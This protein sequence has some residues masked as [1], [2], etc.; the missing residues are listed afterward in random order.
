[1]PGIFQFFTFEFIDIEYPELAIFAG[2]IAGVGII[3]TREGGFGFGDRV[4]QIS[5]AARVSGVAAG[6]VKFIGFIDPGDAGFSSFIAFGLI[7][8]IA[9]GSELK[10]F[11]AFGG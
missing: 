7:G 8:G 1:M 6:V 10:A 2:E 9:A 11:N 4:N 3:V 5:F